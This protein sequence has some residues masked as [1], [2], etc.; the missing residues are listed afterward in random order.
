MTGS[1]FRTWAVRWSYF[2]WAL[3]STC[4]TPILVP[5]KHSKHCTFVNIFEPHYDL[6][7]KYYHP[8][9]TDVEIEAPKKVT[10]LSKATGTQARVWY[11]GLTLVPVLF[12]DF[13]LEGQLHVSESPRIVGGVGRERNSY[14]SYAELGL[15]IWKERRKRG[16]PVV[17]KKIVGNNER[18]ENKKWEKK[19]Q[20]GCLR[21]TKLLDE[22]I[23][24]LLSTPWSPDQIV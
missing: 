1:E 3:L 12:H 6:S 5:S 7:D 19:K 16:T 23:V 21:P 20:K 9:L 2:S 15:R 14:K 11:L 22:D 24:A 13:R 10:Q 4:Y 18:R 17:S 8:Q